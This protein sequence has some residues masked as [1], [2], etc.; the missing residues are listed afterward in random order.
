MIQDPHT[1]NDNLSSRL[2]LIKQNHMHKAF[3]SLTVSRG[4][5]RSGKPSGLNYALKRCWV[6]AAIATKPG[7]S[8]TEYG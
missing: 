2:L 6:S 8:K 3:M 4:V 1:A 5:A 7:A